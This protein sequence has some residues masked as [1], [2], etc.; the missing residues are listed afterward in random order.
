[1][2]TE[3][4]THLSDVL[5]A[6]A[7]AGPVADPERL[8]A[9]VRRYPQYAAELT[10]FAIDLLFEQPAAEHTELAEQDDDAVSPAVA[11]AISHFHNVLYELEKA[12][13]VRAPDAVAANPFAELTRD[14]F[15]MLAKALNANTAFLMKLRDRL[16]EPETVLARLGFCRKLA[17]LL[18]ASL[19]V[20]KAHFRAA[21][22]LSSAERY[23]AEQKPAAVKRESFE[24]A[25]RGSDLSAEQ[26]RYLLG[27]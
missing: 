22:T 25:V 4:A 14:R 16:I 19:D 10:E 2:M 15:R 18:P 11:R 9:F 26:Q 27:L 12:A 23:K 5:Y 6:Y 8:D 3:N 20:V 17:E 1:M 13:D 21:P 24:D 7:V